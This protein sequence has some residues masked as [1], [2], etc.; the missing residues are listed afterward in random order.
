VRA[1]RVVEGAPV[2]VQVDEPD[3]PSGTDAD[4][5]QLDVGSASICGSDFS[6]VKLGV[7]ATLGHEFGGT[8][9]GVPYAVEPMLWCGRCEQC[10][11]GHTQRCLNQPGV[12]G[13]TLDGGLADHIRLPRATLL[14]LPDGLAPEDACLV[15]TASVSWHGVRLAAPEPGERVV[16]VGGGAIGLMAVAA[17]RARGAEVALEARHP[18]QRAAGERLGATTPSGEYDVVIE[19]AGSESGLAR[20]AELARPGGRVV[21]LGVFFTHVA[22]PGVPTLV[23]ELSWKGAMAYGVHDGVRDFAEAAEM[24]VSTPDLADTLITHRFP[25]DDAAEAFRVAGDRAAGAIKVVLQ[26]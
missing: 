26:P 12:I 13:F 25:L 5:V 8:V 1:V 14:P 10:L 6:Y 7:T 21:L 20:C 9:D 3:A 17:A 2:V 15:E 23:K 16:V 18:H 24:I 22:V 19:A 11:S 4:D